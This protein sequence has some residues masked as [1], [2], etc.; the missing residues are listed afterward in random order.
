M[1]YAPKS[2]YRGTPA[3]GAAVTVYTVPAA[4][5]VIV[6]AVVVTNV[7][8]AP[9]VVAVNVGGVALA[10]GQV[11]AANST[12]V[13]EAAELDVLTTGDTVQLGQT[14]AAACTARVTGVTF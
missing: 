6:K 9:A 1:A 8:A 5:N 10:T 11:V 3:T 7:T 2:L 12:L 4:T 14:T 13:I